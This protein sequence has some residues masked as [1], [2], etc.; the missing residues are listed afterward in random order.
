MERNP[1]RRRGRRSHKVAGETAKHAS[2]SVRQNANLVHRIKQRKDA[3]SRRKADRRALMPKGRIKR[4]LWRLHP[5]NVWSYVTSRD[6]M[7]QILKITGIGIAAF[8]ILC[9]GLYAYFRKDLPTDINAELAKIKQATRFYDRSGQHLLYQT[10]G[11]ENRTIIEFKDMSP[12]IRNA[13]VALE[14]KD[15]YKHGGFSLTGFIRAGVN[16]V[17]G[18]PQQ[19]GSTI[20]QQFV[21]N[22]LLSN[23]RTYTRKIKELILSEEIERNYSKD[24][25]LAFYLNQIPY[26]GPNEYGIESASK[27]FFKKN[28]KDLTLD[29]AALLASIPQSPTYFSPYGDNTDALVL[30]RNRVLDLMKDQGYIKKEEADEA[31]KVDTMAKVIP[32]DQK[33]GEANIDSPHFVK[34]AQKQLEAELGANTVLNGGLKVITTLDYDK[35]KAAEKAMADNMKYVEPKG[36]NAALV[37]EDIKTGQVLAYVGSRG[38]S[39]PG[40]GNFDAAQALRQPGSSIK[41]FEYAKLFETGKWGPGSIM[42]DVPTDFGAYKPQNFDKGYRG[43][44]SIRSALAESRNIPAIKAMYIAGQENVM[45]FIQQAGEKSFCTDGCPQVGLSMAIGGAEVKLA[46]HTHAYTLF[47]RGGVY[48]PQ[49][50]VLKVESP[51][52]KVLKEWKD[53][54]G[55]RLID[56]QIAYN[57][58]DIL[59]DNGARAPTFGAN[60]RGFTIPGQTTAAKTGTTNDAKDGWMMGYSTRIITGVWVGNHDNRAMNSTTHLQTGP[61]WSQYMAEAHKGMQDEKFNKPAGIKEIRLDSTTGYQV[62]NGGKVDRFASFFTPK[63]ASSNSKYTIDSVS[64]KLAT[65]CT[66]QRA[67]K[68]M[69]G[70]G[71]VD[72]EIP[73]SDPAYG[74]WLAGVKTKFPQAGGGGDGAAPADK[75][76]VHKCSDAKPSV[77]LSVSATGKMTATVTQGTFAMDVLNFIVDGQI[78]SSQNV[79][80]GTYEFTP[81][82]LSSGSHTFKVEA[83]DKG[84]YDA[85]D[86]KSQT[87]GGNSPAFIS[88]SNGATGVAS[89]VAFSWQSVSG[90]VSYRL[91]VSGG[92]NN[93]CESGTSKNVGMGS[94]NYTATITAYSAAGCSGGAL[95]SANVSFSR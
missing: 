69:T 39:H 80:G 26:G 6:G 82:G 33:S 44:M 8:I 72:A 20:T 78:V 30:K 58:N 14:D 66:P 31:K 28:S 12:Y 2:T 29:E 45:K 15:F 18:R 46:E 74:R 42:Y 73:S 54:E 52:G 65:D 89:P 5:K 34:E 68:E 13:T 37:S 24:Q 67:R 9:V 85:V 87:I 50:Y 21:K 71:R 64:N 17:L 79:G 92:A 32:L 22:A 84:L 36:D 60:A 75:D 91:V 53:T 1:L 4:V 63:K 62:D 25:I 56:E 7:I 41:P 51:T 94:G 93:S 11:K 57:I 43:N 27:S 55:K 48:K 95:S 61:M 10:S 47:A 16:N 3:K 88:P 90:A 23:E 49:A 19:G 76:D 35:Q 83:I 81:S 40:Y 59:S 38:Y 70:A 86:E 77:S